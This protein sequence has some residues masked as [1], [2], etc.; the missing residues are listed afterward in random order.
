MYPP[1]SCAALILPQSPDR[2]D[3]RA[4]FMFIIV[5]QSHFVALWW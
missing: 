1:V 4:F 3:V 2:V 5:T